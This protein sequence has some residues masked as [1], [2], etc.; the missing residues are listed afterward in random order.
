LDVKRPRHAHPCG[1]ITDKEG[2]SMDIWTATYAEA[3]LVG[4]CL[5]SLTV[6]VMSSTLRG[7]T[8]AENATLV[9]KHVAAATRIRMLEF[10]ARDLSSHVAD[11]ERL[12]DSRGAGGAEIIDLRA[13]LTGG[14][15]FVEAIAARL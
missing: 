2:W 3:A 13:E 6:A 9:E 1:E 11:L 4:L 14:R 7:R 8:L 12:R 5:L 10:R 15:R